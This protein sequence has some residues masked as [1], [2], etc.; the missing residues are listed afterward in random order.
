MRKRSDWVRPQCF[1]ARKRYLLS[2]SFRIS[3]WL[4]LRYTMY[5]LFSY[6]TH[7]LHCS[8]IQKH[9]KK[10]RSVCLCN[11]QRVS[12]GSSSELL[13]QSLRLVPHLQLIHSP[14]ALQHSK[15]VSL[16]YLSGS[17]RKSLWNL[18]QYTPHPTWHSSPWPA[19]LQP[20]TNETKA[21]REKPMWW[22]CGLVQTVFF[23]KLVM[24]FDQI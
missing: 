1:S 15:H 7:I 11:Y 12:V 8:M 23:I 6:K 16:A 22:N 17:K 19:A 10:D 14:T 21:E 2:S 9:R 4:C 5:S 3:C 24:L 18:H 13:L 20:G